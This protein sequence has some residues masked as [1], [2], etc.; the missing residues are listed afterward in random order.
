MLPRRLSVRC[1][2]DPGPTPATSARDIW[3]S[4][5]GWRDG[6]R[7]LKSAYSGHLGVSCHSGE[8]TVL[9]GEPP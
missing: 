5:L 2:P 6:A 9:H 1:S 8:D 3:F 7:R 4:L